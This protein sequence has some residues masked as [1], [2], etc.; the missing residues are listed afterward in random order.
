[1]RNGSLLL[2]ILFVSL[3]SNAANKDSVVFYD[4]PDSLKAISFLT[5][6]Q[7]GAINGK[8]EFRAGIKD[9]AVSL[10]LE[11]SKKEIEF[12]FEF[13]STA[14]VVV[15]GFDIE[16]EKGELTWVFNATSNETYK[17]MLSTATDSAENYILYSGYVFLPKENK[18]KLM[19]TCKISNQWGTIKNPAT[20]FSILKKDPP[21]VNFSSIWCQRNNGSWKNMTASSAQPP[22]INLY[23]HTDSIQQSLN[24]VKLLEDAIRTGNTDAK[25]N[26]DGVYYTILKE[27]TGRQV[28]LTDTV[29]AH[30]KGYLF[31]DGKIFDQTKEKPAT[32]ALKRLIRGWQIG[33]P[34][35]KV[36]GK[37]KLVIPSG[38]AYSIRTRAAKI[39]PNSILVFEIEIIEVKEGT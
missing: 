30:Y 23:S 25:Q 7:A 28:Q 31:N 32:F 22:T 4:L 3:I 37:I 26:K 27:G 8:K 19:G 10:Y 12:V 15:T 34:L 33:V 16:V 24:E 9:G 1:M 18:W 5:D 2:S 14:S 17:L 29:V 20:F 39:P 36:G 6:V 21:L 13:P 38:L 35:C 11:K